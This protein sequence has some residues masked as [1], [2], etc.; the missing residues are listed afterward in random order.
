MITVQCNN[1]GATFSASEQHA[2]RRG[3]CKHCGNVVTIPFPA[4]QP[5][6]PTAAQGQRPQ[7]PRSAPPP[8]QPGYPAPYPGY[9]A[10][11]PTYPAQQPYAAP[12]GYA[13]PQSYAPPPAHADPSAGYAPQYQQPVYPQQQQQAAWPQPAQQW[14]AQQSWD[15]QQQGWP[16]QQQPTAEGQWPAE[17]QSEWS[18]QSNY[19]ASTSV[20]LPKKKK[21]AVAMAVWI[22]G[23]I[24]FGAL[25]VFVGYQLASNKSDAPQAT[26]A[27]AVKPTPDPKPAVVDKPVTP[28]A[29]VSAP[30]PAPAVVTPPVNARP[31][32][33]SK[34]LTAEEIVTR[35]G[36]SVVVVKSKFG[37]GT[38]FFIG[39][40]VICTNYHVIDDSAASELEIHYPAVKL[41][42]GFSSVESVLYA[43]P[44]RD[45]AILQLKPHRD[46]PSELVLAD[47][48][49]FRGG[50]P[51][52]VIG[53]PSAGGDK[54]LENA[55]TPG[56]MSTQTDLEGQSYY[57]LSAA[58]NPGN[59]GGPVFDSKGRVIG[60]VT[61]KA[62]YK[63]G[64]A[65]CIPV[66][67]VLSG[68][69]TGK[70]RSDDDIQ[71]VTMEHDAAVVR[72]TLSEASE[73]IMNRANSF[74]R[75]KAAAGKSLEEGVKEIDSRVI[76]RLSPIVDRI[77]NDG[78]AS[79]E[80]KDSLGG[81]WESWQ[82]FRDHC[83][84][85]EFAKLNFSRDLK[86]HY[87]AHENALEKL[88]K[89]LGPMSGD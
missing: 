22:G 53:S 27:P 11:Q 39:P 73:I 51:V 7:P 82:T 68:L 9:A 36:P 4:A 86:T 67:S 23:A 13:A 52:T 31:S 75:M 88:G 77:R 47:Q 32:A 12:Q 17:Q 85:E 58:I 60:V 69:K 14:D 34:D 83:S 29:Q 43:D 40:R 66:D 71:R 76:A 33:T 79:D 87:S 20:T 2:G 35:F 37:S 26:N 80:L 50:Q 41:F 19:S 89:V 48:Y 54:I 78:L 84:A 5:P 16:Q 44:K 3:K 38:G 42:V 25:A 1:C 30:R 6:A 74:P 28:V 59:S 55:V 81:A 64:I 62:T 24:A 61:L 46:L 56:M 18:A 65:F 49:T 45:L 63:E 10:P 8:T 15:A 72:R 70:G 21:P 57:Q